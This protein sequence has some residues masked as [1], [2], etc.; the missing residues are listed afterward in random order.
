[1]RIHDSRLGVRQDGARIVSPAL[2]SQ[3]VSGS[4]LMTVGVNHDT[5]LTGGWL[6]LSNGPQALHGPDFSERYDSVPFT[7]PFDVGFADIGPRA[8]GTQAGNISL[9]DPTGRDRCRAA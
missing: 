5:L 6:D 7:D 9:R 2:N 8:T 4:N 1:M 3:P